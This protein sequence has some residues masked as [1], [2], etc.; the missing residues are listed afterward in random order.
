MPIW[1]AST[2]AIDISWAVFMMAPRSDSYPAVMSSSAPRKSTLSRV[3]REKSARVSV[4]P[5]N[6]T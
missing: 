4:P 3:T 6:V 2:G 5:G 1:R